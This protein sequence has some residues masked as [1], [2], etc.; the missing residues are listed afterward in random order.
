MISDYEELRLQTG[1]A[2]WWNTGDLKG[3]KPFYYKI[4]MVDT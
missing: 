3:N 2:K 1:E 4:P